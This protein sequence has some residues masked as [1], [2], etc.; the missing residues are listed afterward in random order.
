MDGLSGVMCLVSSCA[1]ARPGFGTA[2]VFHL[3]QLVARVV[4][5]F[6]RFQPRWRVWAQLQNLVRKNGKGK[7]QKGFQEQRP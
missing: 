5:Y 6:V 7:N 4:N 1:G 2:E 3:R